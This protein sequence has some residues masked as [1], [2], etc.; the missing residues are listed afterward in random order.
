MSKIIRGFF[1]AFIIG[2]VLCAR[3]VSA[4]GTEEQTVQTEEFEEFEDTLYATAAVTMDADSGRVLYGKNA[5]EPMAMASTTKIMTCILILEEG[6]PEDTVQVSS[7]AASM[8]KVKLYIKKGETYR[9]KD[10]LYS[11]MLESHNDS[12]VALAEYLGSRYLSE[13]AKGKAVCEHTAEESKQA[14]AA[15]AALM[16]RKAKEI[17]HE[18]SYFIT[19]NGLDATETFTGAGESVSQEHHTTA[20]DLAKVM[21][22]CIV[23]SEKKKIFWKSR[24]REAMDFQQTAGVFPVTITMHFYP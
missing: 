24:E 17:G 9:V 21:S 7:Y 22:Y 20:Q 1:C 13:E 5:E 2:F 3:Q 11:L 15:F 8:P 6:S 16:N 4:T 10:L 18:N 23:Q 14:V 19:P 12:A